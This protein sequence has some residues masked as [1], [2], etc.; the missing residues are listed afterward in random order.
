MLRS[1]G[2]RNRPSANQLLS[3]DRSAGREHADDRDLGEDA[4]A[5]YRGPCG[6]QRGE[7][8]SSGRWAAAESH[9]GENARLEACRW[10]HWERRGEHAAL[11]L[12]LRPEGG[13]SGAV[14]QVVAQFATAKRPAAEVRQ[15]LADLVAGSGAR[16]P[17]LDQAL[18]PSVDERLHAGYLATKYLCHLGLREVADLHQEQGGALLG[19]ELREIAEQLAQA[20]ATLDLVGEP[21]GRELHI[22]GRTRGAGGGGARRSGCGRWRIATA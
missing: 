21:G 7:P 19:R 11:L 14:A 17:S 16:V 3:R 9:R 1:A 2:W 13:A 6:P 8:R 4:R 22:L 5:R 18:S 12:D 10:N 20:G 15:L